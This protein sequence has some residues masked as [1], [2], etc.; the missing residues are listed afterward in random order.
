MRHRLKKTLFKFCFMFCFTA[1]VFAAEIV[2]DPYGLLKVFTSDSSQRLDGTIQES[3]HKLFVIKGQSKST[4][5]SEKGIFFILV[6]NKGYN[7]ERPG[8]V[9]VHVAFFGN[10]G[11]AYEFDT[12]INSVVAPYLIEGVWARKIVDLININDVKL[13]YINGRVDW[14]QGQYWLASRGWQKVLDRYLKKS[15]SCVIM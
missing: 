13:G 10:F 1:T 9:K 11:S 7:R 4:S 8:E 3:E 6:K 12:A 14:T 15:E 5:T 2:M